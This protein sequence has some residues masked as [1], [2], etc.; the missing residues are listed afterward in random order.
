MSGLSKN[1]LA[2]LSWCDVELRS[3]SWVEGGR[4]LLFELWPPSPGST[5]GEQPHHT[6]CARWVTGLRIDLHQPKEVGGYLLT[7]DVVIEQEP[8]GVW[9]VQFDFGS[10][11]FVSFQCNELELIDV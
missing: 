9:L 6:I 4:D 11:G 8:E 3:M 10:T 1:Q 5:A 2:E 7:W